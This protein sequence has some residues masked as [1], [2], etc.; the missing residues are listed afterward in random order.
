MAKRTPKNSSLPLP[1]PYAIVKFQGFDRQAHAPAPPERPPSME[2]S[3]F[4]PTVA[5]PVDP[6]ALPPPML[7]TMGGHRIRRQYGAGPEAL[8]AA[9]AKEMAAKAEA[10]AERA[11]L[12]DAAVK[13]ALTARTHADAAKARAAAAAE[14]VAWGDAE[15]EAEKGRVAREEAA[16]AAR[17]E[18]AALIAS[19]KAA[20]MD[21]RRRQLDREPVR[22]SR[23]LSIERL[24]RMGVIRQSRFESHCRS[25]QGQWRRR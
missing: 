18:T 5:G 20:E 17:M 25:F 14:E 13:E 8:A 23:A 15:V 24:L 7:M 12:V 16:Q 11:A 22:V 6:V 10:E 21:R 1:S 4:L 9:E 2:D 3:R 19:A